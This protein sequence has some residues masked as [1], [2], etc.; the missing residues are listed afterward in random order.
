MIN[1]V[2]NSVSFLLHTFSLFT[3]ILIRTRYGSFYLHMGVAGFG[4]GSIIYSCLQFGV[5]FD[6]DG[7]CKLIVIALKPALRI[8][9]MVAQTIFIFSYTDVSYF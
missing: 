3:E 1:I 7:D 4:L 6:L 5:Y 9:Y 8:L 2:V